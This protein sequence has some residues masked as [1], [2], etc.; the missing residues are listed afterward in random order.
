MDPRKS[1]APIVPPDATAAR[2]SRRGRKSLWMTA[3]R[4]VAAWQS[5]RMTDHRARPDVRDLR[6]WPADPAQLVD[7]T[8]CPACFSR[9]YSSR[10]TECGLELGVPA[11]VELLAS[12]T[13]VF[14][15]EQ[16]RQN[17]I[18]RMREAQIGAASRR[19]A[20]AA[21]PAAPPIATAASMPP[22]PRSDAANAA[23]AETPPPAASA[24]HD[25][26]SRSRRSGVQVLL[27]TLGVVLISIT[28]IVFLFVA[29]L[30]ATL[31]VRSVI[32]AV[33]SVLVLG[34]AWLLRARRLP[35]TAEGVA[36][37]AVV[38]LLLD[39]WTV[40]AN[41]LFGSGAL[42]TA[43]Y[44]GLAFAAVAVLL[45]VT[46][47]VSGIRIT[48]YAAAGLTAVSAFLLGFAAESGTPTGFWLGGLAAAVVGAVAVAVGPRSRER[49]ILMWA[50]LTG[51]AV[52]LASG[53]W[54]LS[55]VPWGAAWA[56]AA[57][58]TVN[59]L[60]LVA[61]VVS[62]AGA[63]ARL[64]RAASIGAGISAA[65]APAIGIAAELEPGV[66][67]WTAPAAA[68]VVTAVAA[69]LSRLPGR[70]GAESRG[71]L[72]ASAVV[73]I[74]A[75]VPGLVL[76]A[77][78]IGGRLQASNPL[79]QV[80]ADDRVPWTSAEFDLGTM[81]VSF[82]VAVGAAVVL[83][84]VGGLRRFAAIP[85]AAVMGGALV[86]SAIVPGAAIPAAVFVA[87][88]ASGLA[89]ASTR[90]ASRIPA[91]VAVLATFGMAAAGLAVWTAYSNPAVW[92]W[93][94]AGTLA[95]AVAGRLLAR[96]VWPTT[97]APP[98]GTAHLVV[99]MLVSIAAVFTIPS[100][101]T[102]TGVAPA[103]PWDSPW[104]WLGTVGA[105]LLA[106]AVILPRL[107]AADRVGLVLP[108][109]A[110][111]VASSFIAAFEGTDALG[112]LA[113]AL[114]ALVVIAG[115]RA[116]V[117]AVV[118]VFFA[119]VG[120]LLLALTFDRAFASVPGA[121]PAVLGAAIAVMLAAGLAA[122]LVPR[123]PRAARIAW[124]TS[125]GLAGLLTLVSLSAAGDQQWLVLLLL[126]PVPILVAGLDGDPIGGTAAT[127]H[128]SWLSVPLLVGAVWS[129]LSGDGVD[130][131]EA[132]T[133]PL[134]V[135]LAGAAAL[136]TWRRRT[137][138]PR[139]DG[140]TALFAAAA[141]VAV[142]PSVGSSGD[143]EL[144]TLVL[145]ASGAVIAIAAA[146]LPEAARG[147]PIR[148]LG[149]ATGWVALTGAAVVRGTAVAMGESSRL[150][151]EF[152]PVIALA[153]G[154]LVTVTWARAGSRPAMLAEWLLAASVITA[155]VPTVFAIASGQH[156]VLRVA[157][158]LPIAAVAHV[159]G[160][161]TRARP[162]VGPIFAWSTLGVLVLGGLVAL[163]FGRIEPFDLVTASVGL[164]LIG[165]GGLRIRRSPAVGSWPALGPGL[166]VLLVPSLVAD[167]TD[168]ELWRIVALGVVAAVSVVI[169]AVQRLQAPLLLGGAV[170]LV[171]AI[172]QLWPWIT[173]LYEAVWWWLWLGIAGVILVT[174]AAT[175]ERQ[176]RLA[177]GTFRSLAT[178]R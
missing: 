9:L 119:A 152:W 113:A 145:V 57:V 32:I 125:L 118:R 149:I 101:L 54:A 139:A 20:P 35:G 7:T 1:T 25:D 146:F 70:A 133:L 86:I 23:R 162:F 24:D 102:A 69:A 151:V 99:T 39:V 67:I 96:R 64:G 84:I 168:P 128:L 97:F 156:E 140:R 52:S 17:L 94:V 29:Y 37:V 174:L 48:G 55:D 120:P 104:M 90:A 100:W 176:L 148:L 122:L 155:A 40:R 137:E 65:L 51:V 109:L 136:V 56:L 36:S 130:D 142:L 170:L 34:V 73:A 93:A 153:A 31:E 58:T 72:I 27:L 178:L 22:M 107:S 21:S 131:V 78:A 76:A 115:L 135:V 165:A 150:L 111:S 41:D 59:L 81:L 157:V 43:A 91:L 10:C 71:A 177:R 138:L 53:P 89:V 106:A 6:R 14:E 82:V 47:A 134:A 8:L 66:A 141:A 3:R 60:L 105:G 116:P 42:N 26:A 154:V 161:A 75:S 77:A 61:V 98:V 114:V 85:V 160:A 4:V 169:G 28:A 173:W 2:M 175:Y 12:S 121:P 171:H 45:A 147:V 11:A 19:I 44:T 123:S 63:A 163:T 80:D 18:T 83:L 110:A 127:R 167:F 108:A 62:R 103:E 50:G 129:W 87:V 158:L 166:A 46:R 144:R 30:V 74:I 38:L 92:P 124:C 16:R 159:A 79:W 68:G 49:T 132:Y 88:G 164:A 143:S 95:M 5:V 33:A 126:A 15:E 13:R 117:P 112:W 172:A